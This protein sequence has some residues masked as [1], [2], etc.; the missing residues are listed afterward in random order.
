MLSCFFQLPKHEV[1]VPIFS[2]SSPY[3][4]GYITKKPDP[5]AS[6]VEAA[7]PTSETASTAKTAEMADEG[8]D[9]E[10]DQE[11]ASK[12]ASAITETKAANDQQHSSPQKILIRPSKLGAIEGQTGQNFGSL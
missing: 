1:R 6:A 10:K 3:P 7:A 5:P 12:M 8:D 4:I 11:M 2:P 9:P